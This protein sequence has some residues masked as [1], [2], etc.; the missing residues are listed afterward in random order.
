MTGD[1]VER[2]R[3]ACRRR[4]CGLNDAVLAS[5]AAQSRR[6][7]QRRDGSDPAA[8]LTVL[9]YGWPLLRIPQRKS[10]YR[11]L[12]P[13]CAGV[14]S[15]AVDSGLARSLGTDVVRYVRAAPPGPSMPMV[16]SPTLL[17][18]TLE[19]A[20]VYRP[21]HIAPPGVSDLLEDV[22]QRLQEMAESPCENS[23]PSG[24]A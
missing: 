2:L 5:V 8:K 19:L 12:F 24:M 4:G 10:S 13:I 7:K 21:T 6:L 22:V 1:H 15:V 23:G 20:L 14:S 17:D 3:A 16:F 11:K 18:S 9:K